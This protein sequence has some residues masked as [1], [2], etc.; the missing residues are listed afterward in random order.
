MPICN[1]WIKSGS[2]GELFSTH[3]LPSSIA[4]RETM[5]PKLL[6]VNKK[7]HKIEVFGKKA[8]TKLDYLGFCGSL[9]ALNPQ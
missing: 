2:Y 1:K 9:P 6:D 3:P 8:I 7:M 4:R 5:A